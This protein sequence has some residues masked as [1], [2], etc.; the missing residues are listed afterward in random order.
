MQFPT[1][2]TATLRA[3]VTP[4]GVPRSTLGDRIGGPLHRHES[5]EHQWKLSLTQEKV[6][7]DWVLAQDAIGFPPTYAQ[8]VDFAGRQAGDLFHVHC[9]RIQ[10]VEMDGFMHPF[11]S[12]HARAL[13]NG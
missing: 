7:R 11:P 5:H 10:G 4:I 2:K 12:I 8:V 6:L 3:T 9:P 1:W 13:W